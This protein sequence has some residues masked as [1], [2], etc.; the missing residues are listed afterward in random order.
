MEP[1]VKAVN[2]VHSYR[3]QIDTFIGF[4]EMVLCTLWRNTVLR[5]RNT[6]VNSTQR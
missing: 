2:L 1:C 4:A 6:V 5:Q 3:S